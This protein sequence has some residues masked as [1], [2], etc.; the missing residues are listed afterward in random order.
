MMLNQLQSTLNVLISESYVTFIP[1]FSDV[2]MFTFLRD[3]QTKISRVPS[4]ERGFGALFSGA[5]VTE[6]IAATVLE[7]QAYF[8]TKGLGIAKKYVS[9]LISVKCNFLN[10]TE[11]GG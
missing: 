7:F 3:S 11:D 5:P 8:T 1:P 2:K 6:T 10:T 4:K 9:K